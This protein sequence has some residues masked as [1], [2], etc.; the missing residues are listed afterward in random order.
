MM[1]DRTIII[2]GLIILVGFIAAFAMYLEIDGAFLAALLAILSALA[3]GFTGVVVGRATVQPDSGTKFL[4][5]IEKTGLLKNAYARAK[6]QSRKIQS[7]LASNTTYSRS[8]KIEPMVMGPD[9][10]KYP[11]IW[12]D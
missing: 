12:E 6:R 5:D 9:P 8:S 3:S 11:I 7:R 2:L 1:E 4:R 10:E